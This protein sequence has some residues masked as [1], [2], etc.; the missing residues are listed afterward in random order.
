MFPSGQVGKVP[1]SRTYARL[2]SDGNAASG[3]LSPKA[4]RDLLEELV[5][6]AA[7]WPV[8]SSLAKEHY[9]K[10]LTDGEER[11]RTEGRAEGRA[12]DA[13]ESV[14]SVLDARGLNATESE[15]KRILACA[16]LDELRHGC[17]RRSASARSANC[18]A[19]PAREA[20]LRLTGR[21]F[22]EELK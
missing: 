6:T 19:R 1:S 10:G 9:G 21:P 16:D 17:E 5:T 14:L 4:I 8:Y 7:N 2:R 3:R 12:E 15:R 11:G 13:R 20:F 22:P 18:S